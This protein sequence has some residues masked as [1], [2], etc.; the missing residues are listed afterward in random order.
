M[1][2][3]KLSCSDRFKKGAETL[4]EKS[5]K[6]VEMLAKSLA[7]TL[8]KLKAPFVRGNKRVKEKRKRRKPRGFFPDELETEDEKKKW[9][10]LARQ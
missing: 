3:T 2:N 5:N 6:G 9:T 10:R 8:R 1:E 4:Q 7:S